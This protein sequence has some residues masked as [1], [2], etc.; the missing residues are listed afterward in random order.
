[1][2]SI[3]I[4][5][6]SLL[7]ALSVRAQQKIEVE[8]AYHVKQPAYQNTAE[9]LAGL[10][11]KNLSNHNLN[12]SGWTIYFNF[13]NPRV[14]NAETAAI[15]IEQINGD[16]F[17]LYP[18]QNFKPL[19]KGDS[20]AI[21]ILT[22]TIKNYTDFPKGFY[23]VFDGDTATHPIKL[24]T[25]TIEN[26]N[27]RDLEIAKAN[28][29]KN[30]KIKR[31]ANHEFSPILPTPKTLVRKNGVFNLTRNLNIVAPQEFMAEAKDFAND[32]GKWL[33]FMPQINGP[34]KNNAIIINKLSGLNKEAYQLRV[35]SGGV[36][37]NATTNTGV[38]YA[39]QSFKAL[40]PNKL[41]VGNKSNIGI[42]AIEIDDEPRFSHRAFMMDIAR[43]FQSKAQ[44]KKTIEILSFYKINVL[45][46]HFSDDEGWR[47]EIPGLPELT[48]IG[49]HRGHTLT[50]LDQI[51]PAYGSGPNRNNKTG[52]GYIKRS[53]F[54]ELLKFAKSRHV[55]IIPEIETPGHARAAIK[56]MD[57]RYQYYMKLNNKEEAEK[58]LLRDL[59]D[60]SAYRSIQGFNDNIINV[61]MPSAY[62]FL[63]KV[64][65]ELV[66][67]YKEAGAELQSIHFGGDE[68][69]VGVWEKSPAVNALMLNNQA[70]KTTNELWGYYFG[71][72]N[73]MLKQK[74]LYLSGWEEIGLHKVNGKMVLDNRFANENFHA[75]VWNN[76][77]GNEDLAYILA[78]AGYKVVLTNVTNMYLDLAY[79][80]SH[81]ERG[82]YWGGY[83][84]IDKPY[85]LIP[86]NY[87]KNQTED[88]SGNPIKPGFYDDKVQLTEKGKQN[89]V[90]LQGPLWAEIIFTKEAFEYLLFPKLLGLAE[91][92][93]AQD[94][95]WATEPDKQKSEQLYQVDYNRFINTVAQKELKRLDYVL[96]G[97]N[98]RIPTPGIK[99]MNGKVY[100]N[101]QYPTLD[102]RY[103]TN[104]TEPTLKS[105]K[106]TKPLTKGKKM[107]FKL[108]NDKGRG[109]K[110]V[111]FDK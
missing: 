66:S 12:S 30:T 49:A 70:V 87:Y 61:A 7:L 67:M 6:T 52:S 91:R 102:I 86:F 53:E 45:H 28:Y 83:V 29:E 89:I 97:F 47:L 27:A 109:G 74:G 110:T 108:F 9:S 22:R 54:V 5:I 71:K 88:A 79:N 77:S 50:E 62:A 15:E 33:G 81:F 111:Y 31:L 98:Y 8:I 16:F 43:N 10:T 57:A 56:S 20:F 75:D 37:I 39:L 59:N 101:A 80:K 4:L 51:I 40:L 84:D 58:Y 93:W 23:L 92:A 100:A 106:Y 105:L 21:D 26:L 17:K 82:Q 96:D 34:K 3:I 36:Q 65:D 60:K 44:I 32:L 85:S 72:I 48:D 94:P 25:S 90:G 42:G 2:K 35:S 46:F 104:G 99:V 38:F 14:L 68:V 13:S 107:A 103:T 76:L 69:P 78:N 19:K 95:V 64:S 18:K 24:K 41:G 55:K 11:I 63:E 73:N 1:M